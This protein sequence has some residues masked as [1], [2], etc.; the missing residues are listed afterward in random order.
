[1]IKHYIYIY[2][3]TNI[4]KRIALVVH[5]KTKIKEKLNELREEYG[6]STHT[7]YTDDDTI[8]SIV[9][10]DPFFEGVD[11]Y[12]D[13]EKFSKKITKLKR[14]SLPT[15][16]EFSRILLSYTSF[17]K[18]EIQKILYLVYSICLE[19]GERIFDRLPLAYDYGPVFKD[20]YDEY[21]DYK[22]YEKISKEHSV[23]DLLT[24][25]KSI[26]LDKVIPIVEEV[27]KSTEGKTGGNLIDI[28]HAKQGPWDK[29]HIEG[30]NIPIDDDAIFEYNHH[31]RNKLSKSL[32]F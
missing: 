20:V 5:D 10:F 32:L 3:S 16:L 29:V 1:M 4:D 27:L 24:L 28:T 19:N 15:P 8:N 25:S 7:L 21:K 22:K 18:L 11:F 6:L 31:V 26:N 9:L 2:T 13:I 12:R 30:M 14:K 17:D 23:I